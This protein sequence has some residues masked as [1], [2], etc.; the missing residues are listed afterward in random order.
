MNLARLLFGQDIFISYS[1]ADAITYAAALANQLS[2]RGFACF[3]DQWG[4][5]PG[6]E[7]PRR[8]MY[9][10]RRSSMLV[11]VG[12]ARGAASEAVEREIAAFLE[13]GRAIVPVS[14]EG[15]LEHGRWYSRIAGA[16]ISTESAA[17]LAGGTPSEDVLRRIESSFL[18]T[19]RNARVRRGFIAAGI[20]LLLLMGLAA[21]RQRAAQLA[22][23]QARTAQ[24]QAKA[25]QDEAL[26]RAHEA[27]EA[28]RR[29]AESAAEAK[30]QETIA[31]EN[32]ARALEQQKLA[33]E[34]AKRGQSLELAAAARAVFET[35]PDLGALLAME[36]FGTADMFESRRAL[37]GSLAHRP[38][39]EAVIDGRSTEAVWLSADGK[40]VAA[41]QDDGIALWSAE[42]SARRPRSVIAGKDI[43]WKAVSADFRIVVG[44]RW[45][46]MTV[47]VRA[48]NGRG[49]PVVF[50]HPHGDIGLI[51]VSPDGTLIAIG[52]PDGVVTLWDA[53]TGQAVGEPLSSSNAVPNEAFGSVVYP[54]LVLT[55]TPDGKA[56][57]WR[58]SNEKRSTVD[59][60]TRQPVTWLPDDFPAE[61]AFGADGSGVAM[62]EG[63]GSLSSGRLYKGKVESKRELVHRGELHSVAISPDGRFIA[64]GSEDGMLHLFDH[65]S[66]RTPIRAHEGRIESVA[67][68][69]DGTRLVS[70]GADGMMLWRTRDALL[71]RSVAELDRDTLFNAVTLRFTRDGKRLLVPSKDSILL[72]DAARAT[73]DKPA[74]RCEGASLAGVAFHP[75]GKTVAAGSFSHRLFFADLATRRC[76]EREKSGRSIL[77]NRNSVGALAFSP[78]GKSLATGDSEGALVVW[79]LGGTTLRGRWLREPDNNAL[80]IR[81]IVWTGGALIVGGAGN[82]RLWRVGARSVR[83]PSYDSRTR[84]TAMSADGR[85]LAGSAER[86]VHLWDAATGR[87]L[88]SLAIDNGDDDDEVTA[89]AIDASLLAVG[90]QSG[91]LF[92]FD[93]TEERWLGELP[94][95]EGDGEIRSLDFSPQGARLAA[96]T[97]KSA[98][99]WDL[100][101]RL[102]MRRAGELANRKLTDAERRRYLRGR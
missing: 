40:T 100:D 84:L 42:G 31:R 55:F 11:V 45:D 6:G 95:P 21:W 68:S 7:I 79:S 75:D 28:A 15:A 93:I 23:A 69:G 98:L 85:L 83:L 74:I 70:S 25:A 49:K 99:I 24:M 77:T 80:A 94:L 87:E 86:R 22:T 1:R 16:S 18:F 102:W 67:F 5:E 39:L 56:L 96:L 19:K 12:S 73:L 89:I 90:H 27:N 82:E 9:T 44:T 41:Q 71:H 37:L 46:D 33:E 43:R 66:R 78:D 4:S 76:R 38:L 14:V 8:V 13:T 54:V 64:A 48:L 34:R 58:T 26:R 97:D 30:R 17:A 3:L 52:S 29:A 2:A 50:K 81:S 59:L 53:K 36:S 62:I 65:H 72:I 88:A 10:L 51:A 63:D 91:R 101:T 57:H 60:A 20:G 35:E 61:F 32:A 92:L 47:H